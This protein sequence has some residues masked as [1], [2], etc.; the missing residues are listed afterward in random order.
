MEVEE[1]RGILRIILT[2]KCTQRTKGKAF[3]LFVIGCRSRTGESVERMN[4]SFVESNNLSWK[5]VGTPPEII[6][7]YILLNDGHGVIGNDTR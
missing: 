3:N 1:N 5:G 2:E 7:I 4:Y 6:Y